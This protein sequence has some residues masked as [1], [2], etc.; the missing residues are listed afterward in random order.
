MSSIPNKH[1]PNHRTPLHPS[2]SLRWEGRGGEW[3]WDGNMPMGSKPVLRE[4]DGMVTSAAQPAQRKSK[5]WAGGSRSQSL[6][7]QDRPGMRTPPDWC[8]PPAWLPALPARSPPACACVCGC[9]C[10]PVFRPRL[11]CYPRAWHLPGRLRLEQSRPGLWFGPRLVWSGLVWCLGFTR[12]RATGRD[13]PH[14]DPAPGTWQLA[15]E[16]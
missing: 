11:L 15:P 7:N 6:L 5:A 10:L 12:C 16:R 1:R 2:K 3:H 4:R 8:L 13:G 14:L 9:A